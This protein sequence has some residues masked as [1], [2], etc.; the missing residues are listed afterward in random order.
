MRN[1]HNEGEMSESEEFETQFRAI[2]EKV[3]RLIG[4]SKH[5][6]E[7]NAELQRKIRQLEEELHRKDESV[8]RRDEEKAFIRSR[9]DNLLA[10]LEGV[11]RG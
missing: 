10:K 4:I 6:H 7:A 9:I 5:L 3:E 8:K 11:T 1:N 2:E